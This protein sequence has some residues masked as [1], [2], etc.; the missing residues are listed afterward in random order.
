MQE[1][2]KH[3]IKREEENV[4]SEHITSLEVTAYT[5]GGAAPLKHEH[6]V[7]GTEITMCF[8]TVYATLS[9]TLLIEYFQCELGWIKIG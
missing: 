1:N 6:R 3:Q 4:A 9:N 8:I 5:T 7:F 2:E